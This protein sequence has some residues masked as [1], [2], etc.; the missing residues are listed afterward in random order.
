V[1]V[2]S[3]GLVSRTKRRIAS[4]GAIPCTSAPTAQQSMPPYNGDA[5]MCCS[6]ACCNMVVVLPC[7]DR[8]SLGIYGRST[9]TFNAHQGK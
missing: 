5:E 1:L 2:S 9:V 4:T 8:V 3:S 6:M 7:S